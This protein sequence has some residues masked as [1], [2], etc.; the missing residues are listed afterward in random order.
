[1]TTPPESHLL[2]WANRIYRFMLRGYPLAFRRTYSRE[3]ALTFRARAH[4]IVQSKGTL[5]LVPFMLHTVRDW[6]AT[7]VREWFDMDSAQTLNRITL[8]ALTVLSLTALAPLLIMALPA[9]LTGQVPLSETANEGTGAHI[10]QMSMG[11]LVPVGL[12]FLATADWKQPTRSIRHMAFPAA[13]VAL[14]LAMLF[15]FEHVYL[16]GHGSPL[17]RPGLPLILLRRMLAAFR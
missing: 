12:T 9:M 16:P 5:S 15:Y 11:A 8:V 14:A 4:D 6:A 2:L 17:P 13:A 10:F 7:V 3:M 1:M